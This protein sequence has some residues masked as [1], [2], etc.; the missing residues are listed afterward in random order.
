MSCMGT[1]SVYNELQCLRNTSWLFF[2]TELGGVKG[3]GVEVIFE[4]Y[5]NPFSL[6]FCYKLQTFV[7]N[8]AFVL[9]I[10]FM[11]SQ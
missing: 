11:H 7:G 8:E 4:I 1:S 9:F 3:G 6:T 10:T 2:L 5:Y